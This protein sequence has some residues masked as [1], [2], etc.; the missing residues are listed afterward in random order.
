MKAVL[1]RVSSASV[2]VDG[3]VVGAIDCPTTCGILALVGVTHDDGPEDCAL[4]ARKI[5]ELR[6]LPGEFRF[7]TPRH[8][9]CWS[10]SSRC[11]DAP[12]KVG[13]HPGPML[14]PQIRRSRSSRMLRRGY[15]SW[16]LWWSQ[17]S[18]VR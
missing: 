16:A 15:E 7:S 13:V 10:A 17:V 1:T 9:S 5:A 18:S 6:I 8:L 4:M 12:P 11:M 3:Q 2:S 14:L